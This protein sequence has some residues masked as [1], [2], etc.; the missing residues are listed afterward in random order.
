M[1][2]LHVDHCCCR[3]Y[4]GRKLTLLCPER[5]F[6]AGKW[7]YGTISGRKESAEQFRWLQRVLRY[8]CFGG[9]WEQ[10]LRWEWV[11]PQSGGALKI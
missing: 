4:K 5:T 8:R 6:L 10:F 7:L 3:A 1:I 11:A 2:R 9:V